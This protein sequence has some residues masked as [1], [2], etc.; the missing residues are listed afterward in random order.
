VSKKP[1][2]KAAKDGESDKAATAEDA[3]KAQKA[4]RPGDT[5]GGEAGTE[6]AEPAKKKNEKKPKPPQ[7]KAGKKKG[8]PW[9]LLLVPIALVAAFVLAFTLPPTHAMIMKSPLGPLLARFDH[10]A[11]KGALAAGTPDPATQVKQ[12]NDALAA[13]KNTG[14]QKDQQIAALQAQMKS[15]AATPAPADAPSP[16]PKPTPTD[17]P[18]DVKRAAAYWAGMDADKAADIIKQLP[19]AYVKAVFG[20]MPADAVAD[21]MSELPPKTAARLTSVGGDTAP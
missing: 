2:K 1:D 13:E 20:Q 10:S 15:S 7:D 16:T 14:K 8:I 12:L 11:A 3:A 4:G 21:I 5:E 6:A 9:V 17:V 19:D 18:D